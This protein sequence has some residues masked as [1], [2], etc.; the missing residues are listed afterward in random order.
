MTL[1]PEKRDSCMG[2]LV[3]ETSGLYSLIFR[4]ANKLAPT[5]FLIAARGDHG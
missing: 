1:S 3:G 5:G 2:Q 4:L